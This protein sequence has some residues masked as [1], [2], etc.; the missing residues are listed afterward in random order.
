MSETPLKTITQFSFDCAEFSKADTKGNVTQA[1]SARALL[2][3]LTTV[4]TLSK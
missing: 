3:S 2:L 1:A 4:T